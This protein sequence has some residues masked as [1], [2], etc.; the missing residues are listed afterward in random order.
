MSRNITGQPAFAAFCGLAWLVVAAQLVA[1]YWTASGVTFPDTDDA[2]RLV[3]V[4]AY[5]A[6]QGWF[7]LHEARLF[8]PVGYDTHWSRLVDAG[9]AGLFVVFRRF[10]DPALAERLMIVVWPVLWLLPTMAAAAAIGWRLAGREAAFILLLLAIFSGPG[11][12]QFRPA[13]IDHHNVQIALAMLTVAATVWADRLRWA[14]WAAG[15]LT[16]LALAIGLEGLP[17][18][19]SCGAA[20]TVRYIVR[21]DGAPVLRAY[22]LSVAAS[23]LLAF[24][25]NIPPGLWGNSGC[26]ALA[27]NSAGAVIIT[28]AGLI[29]VADRLHDERRWARAAA[30]AGVAAVALTFCGLLE[31]RCL[32]G[33]YA[34]VDPAVRPIWLDHVSET[35]SLLDLARKAW[36]TGIATAA[37]PALTLLA[38]LMLVRS[39]QPEQRE[40]GPLV[41]IA[42]AVLGLCYMLVAM[43]GYSLSI[44]LGIPIVA[45]AAARLFGAFKLQNLAARF[46]IALLITPTAVTV[47]AIT[48][49]SA[50]RDSGLLDLNSPERQACIHRG[51]YAALAALP[52]GLIAVNDIEWGPYL[53]AWTPHSVLAAA[54]HRLSPAII[55]QHQVFAWPP[56]KAHDLIGRLGARYIVVCGPQGLTGLGPQDSA[57]SLLGRLRAGTVPDWLERTP[58]SSGQPIAVYRV[59]P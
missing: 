29:L 23:T 35:H 22:G 49:A 36:G 11:L 48:I 6:G 47:G 58:E 4:R 39:P 53:L 28:G 3:E 34:L 44:W 30:V 12:Q 45:A 13:R 15:A 32:G 14:P 1:E 51:N 5:L 54:Y 59:R 2:M 26:D 43:R 24:L 40:F 19:V 8:P 55:A 52:P 46:A 21:P 27:I 25:L 37:F 18:L 20:L 38:L 50:A 33:H 31:P 42:A 16:G 7:D 10:T 57:T 17:L 41:A 9:L 56:D